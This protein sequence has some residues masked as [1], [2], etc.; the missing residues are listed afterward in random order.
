LTALG[1]PELIAS[2]KADYVAKAVQWAEAP[3]RLT[4]LKIRIDQAIRSSSVFDPTA[5][6]R[7]LETAF[8]RIVR[9]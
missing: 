9:R 5:F 4:T 8:A 6:A 2:D 3:E 7:S 1:L